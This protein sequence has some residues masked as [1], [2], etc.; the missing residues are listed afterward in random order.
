MW[1]K[2]IAFSCQSLSPCRVRINHIDT[3]NQCHLPFVPDDPRTKAY[4]SLVRIELSCADRGSRPDAEGGNEE[5]SS[6]PGRL[7]C[8]ILARTPHISLPPVTI[9]AKVAPIDSHVSNEDSE[10]F[11]KSTKFFVVVLSLDM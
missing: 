11:T 7:Y 5:V 1:P 9:C 8:F 4:C 2:P 3:R 10:H 6:L